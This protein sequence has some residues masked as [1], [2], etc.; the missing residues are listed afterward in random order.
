MQ[1]LVNAQPNLLIPR[2]FQSFMYRKRV[3][4]VDEITNFETWVKVMLAVVK[5]PAAFYADF[6]KVLPPNLRAWFKATEGEAKIPLNVLGCVALHFTAELDNYTTKAEKKECKKYVV[7]T[8]AK[9]YASKRATAVVLGFTWDRNTKVPVF[10]NIGVV[11]EA[12]ER[13]TH[14]KF[15]FIPKQTTLA[16]KIK[17]AL[18]IKRQKPVQ[19]SNPVCTGGKVQLSCEATKNGARHY[20]TLNQKRIY[21]D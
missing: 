9:N 5:D 20:V 1:K 8:W 19:E 21:L 15:Y 17:C 12:V 10:A 6:L 14:S 11:K 16:N 13:N 3:M 4:N 18:W 7:D 2:Y